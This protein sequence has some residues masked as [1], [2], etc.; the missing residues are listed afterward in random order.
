MDQRYEEFINQLSG[1]YVKDLDAIS[2]E[3]RRLSTQGES[4]LADKLLKYGQQMIAEHRGEGE[5]GFRT[6]ETDSSDMERFYTL[7]DAVFAKVLD[8]DYAGANDFLNRMKDE[9]TFIGASLDALDRDETFRS[10]Q[11]LTEEILYR[12]EHV[13][14]KV[15]ILGPEVEIWLSLRG[16]MALELKEL[17]EAAR[18]LEQ[19]IKVNPMSTVNRLSLSKV[20][21]LQGDMTR[22]KTYNQEAFESAYRAADFSNCFSN[23]GY[24]L[25]KENRPSLALSCSMI[26]KEYDEENDEADG[27]LMLI[28]GRFPDAEPAPVETF[29]EYLKERDIVGTIPPDRATT[30]E[31]IAEKAEE[32]GNIELAMDIYINLD[33]LFHD[34]DI[35]A[36]IHRLAEKLDGEFLPDEDAHD[37]HHGDGECCGHHGEDAHGHHHGD[38]E[39]CGHHGEGGHHHHHGDGECCGHHGEGGHGHHE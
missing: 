19:A 27:N 16:G 31:R 37:H 36:N 20:Y 10:F 12:V 24:F 38:G 39:C 28:Q 23:E 17:D 11:S 7:L 30:L 1:D 14:E 18:Y 35:H 21:R 2:E 5:E 6:I 13:E 32:E 29:K 8:E 33:A 9:V 15:P 22:A 34:E 25:Y 4:E 3:V 26:A